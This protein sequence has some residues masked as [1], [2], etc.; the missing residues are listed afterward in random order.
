MRDAGHVPQFASHEKPLLIA[1]M[2]FYRLTFDTSRPFAQ[3]QI[4]SDA[5]GRRMELGTF[6]KAQVFRGPVP[7]KAEIAHPGLIGDVS[8]PVEGPVVR[9]SLAAEMRALAGDDVQW[10]DVDVEGTADRFMVMNTL[11]EFDCVDEQRSIVSYAKGD[12]KLPPDTRYRGIGQLHIRGDVV[13]N[14]NVFRVAHWDVALIVSEEMRR[15]L[16]SH[17]ATGVHFV[18]V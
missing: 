16:E 13:G 3:L 9:A 10:I 18:P 8:F 12:A 5:S 2:R 14:S 15:L 6:V 7:L 1:V 4:C 17:E 11:R